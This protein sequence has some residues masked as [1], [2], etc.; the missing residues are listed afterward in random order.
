MTNDGYTNYSAW[1]DWSGERYAMFD[2]ADA[3]YFASELARSGLTVM[4][5]RR[6]LEIGFGNATFAG[7]AK[8]VGAIYSGTEVIPELV[9]RG[10]SAGFDM[11]LSDG[12]LLKLAKNDS[13]DLLWALDV[14]EHIE[15]N[16]LRAMLARARECLRTGGLIIARVPS[17]DSPFSRAIQHGDLTH[18]TILGSSAIQQLADEVNLQVVQIREPKYVFGGLGVAAFGRRLLVEAVRRLFFPVLTNGFMGG[19]APVLTPNLVFVLKKHG[20]N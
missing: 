18:R 20:A 6:V 8:H 5:D 11:H 13:L 12:P 14:F 2:A 9:A 15:A 16:E 7:W 1:K 4:K 3:A 10:L 19:G 17:G